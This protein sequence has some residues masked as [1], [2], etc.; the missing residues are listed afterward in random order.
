MGIYD[1]HAHLND[2]LYLEL[3]TSSS[4]IVRDALQAN[5]DLINNVGFDIKSSKIAVI[6][7]E[8]HA[9]VYAI[10]GIHP[11]DVHLFSQEAYEQL[12]VLANANK[13]V[14]IGEIGL[15]YFRSKQ[16]I[17]IQ[18]DA[19][20]I[21]IEIAQKHNLPIMA[22]IK[23][24]AGSTKAFDDAIEIFKSLDCKDVVIHDFSGTKK[25]VDQIVELGYYMSIN[26]QV[27]RNRELAKVVQDIPIKN[28]MIESDSPYQ[29]P[30]PYDKKVNYPKLLPLVTKAIAKLK[31]MNEQELISATRN[32]ATTFFNVKK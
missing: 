15:D 9:N 1:V 16:Y 23:D 2:N 17:Q 30:K 6:Q 20:K 4:D 18:K 32:N 25:Q 27:T 29:T 19:L 12:D 31:N 13:V 5:V 7:A 21:Q 14:A 22:H 24:V 3:D 11:N 8:K 28:L 10:V 26:G